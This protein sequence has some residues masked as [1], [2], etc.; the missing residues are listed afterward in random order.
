M[1]VSVGLLLV[2]IIVGHGHHDM[3]DHSFDTDHGI[4]DW[5]PILSFRFWVYGVGAFG[6]AG[7][8]SMLFRV[9]NS[10]TLAIVTGVVTG[11]AVSILAKQL[12]RRGSTSSSTTYQ[13]LLHRWGEVS[14]PIRSRAVGKVVVRYGSDV[15]EVQA[16][17]INPDI[18]IMPKEKVILVGCSGQ[19][20]EVVAE[21]EA[22]DLS[23]GTSNE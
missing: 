7:F 8:L 4:G 3:G 23:L 13:D 17:A 19:V 21:S 11:L 9:P 20:F 1:I 10:L 22:A 18:E 12:A 2:G 16:R 6:L 15:I 14:V 5:L